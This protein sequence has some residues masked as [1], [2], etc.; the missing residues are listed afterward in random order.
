MKKK[1][2]QARTLKA[3]SWNLQD[4]DVLLPMPDTA[5]HFRGPGPI[6]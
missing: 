2:Q 5:G 4:E 1:I 3:I 6:P